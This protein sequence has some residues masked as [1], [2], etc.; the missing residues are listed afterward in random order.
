MKVM[1][2][3]K[4]CKA[5]RMLKTLINCVCLMAQCVY[6]VQ[7]GLLCI[8]VCVAEYRAAVISRDSGD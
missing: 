6:L 4:T 5:T 8:T 2:F 7:N 3:K 1:G